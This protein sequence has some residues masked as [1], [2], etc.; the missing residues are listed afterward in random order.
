VI[1]KALNLLMLVAAISLPAPEALSYPGVQPPTSSMTPASDALSFL[2]QSDAIALVDVRK[3]FRETVPRIFAGDAAKLAQVN[4]EIDKFKSRTGVDLRSFD[5]VVLGMRYTYPSPTITKIE[6][7]VIAHGAFD[8]KALTAAEKLA[9][10]GKYRE[11]KYRGMTISIINVNDQIKLLGL[12]NVRLGE[13]AICA[14]DANTLAFGALPNVRS[15]I[16]A[17]RRGSDA[18]QGLAALASRDPNAVIGFGANVTGALMKNLNVGNDAIAKDVNSIRQVYGSIGTSEA[19][20]ALFLA[21]RTDS[22][23][24]AKSVSETV[25]GLKQLGAIVIVRLAPPKRAL[26]QTALDNL[27]IT[28]RGSE[29]E[30]RTQVAAASLASFVK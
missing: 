28:R 16:D 11:E 17:G 19:E 23:E 24:A 13:L 14:L 3:L 29:V 10:Q 27:K 26:A 30:V 20:V 22:P 7:L 5:R 1:K 9:T 12:W 6:T 15:A 4:S 8:L 18:N 25:I 2:P 21:A